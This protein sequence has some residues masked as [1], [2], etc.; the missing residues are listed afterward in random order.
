MTL[1]LILSY[2]T[3]IIIE[4]YSGERNTRNSVHLV[5]QRWRRGTDFY[6]KAQVCLHLDTIRLK[7][8]LNPGLNCLDPKL[9]HQHILRFFWWNFSIYD[10][11]GYHRW[12]KCTKLIV[13]RIPLSYTGWEHQRTRC[14]TQPSCAPHPFAW[15]SIGPFLSAYGVTRG[16]EN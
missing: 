10:A 9:L 5:T 4:Y 1:R 8:Y 12:I 3:T 2:H 6:R 14:H 16:T 15:R 7:R 11:A 13:S